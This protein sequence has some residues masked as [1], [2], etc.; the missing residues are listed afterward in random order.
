[1]LA[2]ALLSA[3]GY[4]G[5]PMPPTLDIPVTI[6]DFRAWEDGDKI[7]FAFTLPNLTTENLPLTS[8]RS[9]ELRIGENESQS[10]LI[11]LQLSK[12]GPIT[13]EIP[14]KDWIGK[15]TVLAV[16]ATGPKGK[17]SFWSNPVSLVVIQPLATPSTLKV[18]NVEKGVEL[19][20][21]GMGPRYR[22]FRAEADGQPQQL[23]D[24]DGPRYLDETTVYGT[25]YRYVI[26]AIAA[27]N[28]WSVVSEPAVI[29][30]EDK[31]APAVP[32]GLGAVPTPQSIELSWTRNT[33]TD[34]RGYNIFRSVDNAPFEKIATFVEVPTFSDSKIEG[35]K[36]YRYQVSA[37]DL[38]GN[39]ST[40]T[41]PV[42]ATAQ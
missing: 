22:I 16:R 34:F 21:T 36:K 10:K 29:T 15:S 20:W 37:V 6:T 32:E 33:E 12:P 1:V 35:G 42:E 18:Q 23:A 24:S 19:T 28:Q 17:P 7:E 31:F 11:P 41:A 8:V 9:I 2:A 13:G 3:C 14:A 27:E 25:R 40:R 26:Q 30:P 38:T 4:V 5:P 39:E